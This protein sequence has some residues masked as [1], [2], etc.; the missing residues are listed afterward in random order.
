MLDAACEEGQSWS[1]GREGGVNSRICPRSPAVATKREPWG[2][3]PGGRRGGWVGHRC[4]LLQLKS[5]VAVVWAPLLVGGKTAP[6]SMGALSELVGNVIMAY[7]DREGSSLDV[8]G[9][10]YGK[11]S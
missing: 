8:S 6:G 10:H 3:L 4:S 7:G 1:G 2:L 9:A 11:D 5:V